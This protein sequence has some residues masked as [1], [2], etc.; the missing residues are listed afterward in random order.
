MRNYLFIL[1]ILLMAF[2]SPVDVPVDRLNVKGPLQFDNTSFELVWTDKPNE[3][4]CIQ[5]YLPAGEKV[6]QFNQMLTLHVFDKPMTAED[7][8]RLKIQELVKRKKTD[9]VCQFKLTESPDG[10]EFMVDFLLGES[11]DD[12]MT[13]V[14]FNLYHYQ[15]IDLGNGRKGIRVYAYSKRA[16]GDN[17]T[18]FLQNLDR[19]RYLNAMI[20]SKIP[21][22]KLIGGQ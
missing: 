4:Y 3:T 2:V 14:E 8:A 19:T 13:I 17:I 6:E 20:S 11:K 1:S 5:E 12:M 10:K 15:Q 16:Y 22:V 7:A 18:S 9:P 21:V